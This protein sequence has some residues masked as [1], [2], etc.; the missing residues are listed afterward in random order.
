[1]R[2]LIAVLAQGRDR[3]VERDIVQNVTQKDC[4]SRKE[5]IAK[6]REVTKKAEAK[7]EERKYTGTVIFNRL[8]LGSGEFS[9]FDT[10]CSNWREVM[11]RGA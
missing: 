8:H 11:M 3:A 9:S 4:V 10:S 6:Q 5:K 1:M 2:Q 7:R